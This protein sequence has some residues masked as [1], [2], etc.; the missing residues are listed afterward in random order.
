MREDRE[1]ERERENLITIV[2]FVEILHVIADVVRVDSNPKA[3]I[4]PSLS[5][6]IQPIDRKTPRTFPPSP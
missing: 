4:Q 6:A 3:L 1:R 2:H 5:L